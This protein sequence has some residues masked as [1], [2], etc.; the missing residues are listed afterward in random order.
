MKKSNLMHG[1]MAVAKKLREVEDIRKA[2][3]AALPNALNRNR[4]LQANAQQFLDNCTSLRKQVINLEQQ[5]QSA[6]EDV[7][8]LEYCIDVDSSNLARM[9]HKIGVQYT[10]SNGLRREVQVAKKQ[11]LF[12][13][14]LGTVGWV[15]LAITVATYV[16]R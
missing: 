12:N 6:C 14:V 3:A 7:K 2:V 11:A 16:W 4:S 13:L 9:Q 8:H 15:I 5:L 10:I 1:K